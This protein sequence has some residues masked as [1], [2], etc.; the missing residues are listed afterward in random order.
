[1]IRDY[2]ELFELDDITKK[3][4]ITLIGTANEGLRSLDFELPPELEASEPPEA[5]DYAGMK[6]V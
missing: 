6:C 5:R 3:Q 1:M 4:A 2:D